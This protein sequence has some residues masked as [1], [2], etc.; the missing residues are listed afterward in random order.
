[1]KTRINPDRELVRQF[2]GR[3]R[4]GL[5]AIITPDLQFDASSGRRFANEPH[6]LKHAGHILLIEL[7]NDIAFLQT[8]FR[9]GTVRLNVADH[10]AGILLI[11]NR[12]SDPAG[13]L[14]YGRQ[15]HQG[16]PK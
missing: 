2:F 9:S 8:G 13:L 14:G 5:I 11:F 16:H 4:K 12:Y 3:D 15:R 1:M 10:G 6:Q 7:E